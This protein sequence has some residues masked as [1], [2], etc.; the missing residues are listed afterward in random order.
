MARAKALARP[1]AGPSDALC[2]ASLRSRASSAHPFWGS[3]KSSR[4]IEYAAEYFTPNA[5][6]ADMGRALL[7]LMRVLYQNFAAVSIARWPSGRERVRVGVGVSLA[8]YKTTNLH[9]STQIK[10]RPQDLCRFEKIYG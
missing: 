1:L 5:T 9:T 7:M 3:S 6:S 4:P 10:K 2:A 8:F